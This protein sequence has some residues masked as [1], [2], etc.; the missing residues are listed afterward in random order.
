M[1]KYTRKTTRGLHDQDLLRAAAMRVKSGSSLRK[2]SKEVGLPRSTVR[3]A[4]AK[5]DAAEDP[6]SVELATTFNFKSV[7]SA[8]KEILLKDYMI[9]AQHMHHGLTKKEAG[10]LAY[11]YAQAKGKN[12]PKNWTENKCAGKDWMNSF[13]SRVGLSLRSSETTSLARATSFNRTNGSEFFNNLEELLIKPKYPPNRIYNLDETGVTTV[14]KTPKVVAE[15]GSKQVGR[16][17]S[18]ERGTL[19]TVVGCINAAGQSIA[20]FFV[21]PRV[22][23]L[24]NFLN[25]TPPGSTGKC[26]PSGWMTAEIFPD[27]IRHLIS[28]TSCSPTNRLLLIMDNHDSHVSLSVVNLCRENGIDVLTLP[29]HCSHKLQ[30][31]DVAVYGPFK[32]YYNEAANSW[33]I[34]NP[35]RR[36]TI[37]EIGIFVGI[38]FP[39]A[40]VMENVL[41][42]FQKTGIYPFNRN[43]FQD[44]DFL[45]AFVTDRPAPETSPMTGQ[46]AFPSTSPGDETLNNDVLPTTSSSVISATMPVTPESVRPHP[47]ASFYARDGKT[48]RKRAKSKIL[49]NT[50]EKNGLEEEF[51]LKRKK[52]RKESSKKTA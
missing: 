43:V 41:S 2:V 45:S 46:S 24:Q 13:M 7:F 51:E 15:K 37:Y 36:I 19:V 16:I 23:W 17:T 8:N 49:T 27:M 1:G 35:N 11:E 20:P 29:P 3:R 42:G 34:S 40:F 22:N 50:P 32:R 47:K 12:M 44:H 52:I 10:Q 5:L 33:M 31:L 9:T 25:G 4:V 21:F 30:P 18:A 38:A 39:R 14:Q 26:Q 28:Q 48:S 6:Q